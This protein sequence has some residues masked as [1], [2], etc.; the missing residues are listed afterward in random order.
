[1]ERSGRLINHKYNE[2]FFTTL[3]MSGCASIASIVDRIMVGHLLTANDLNATNLI[4]PLIY[5]KENEIKKQLTNASQFQ[6]LSG[7]ALW[8][9]LR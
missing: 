7:P 4:G 2:Y 9:F 3:A 6:L 1:M 8:L 5:I